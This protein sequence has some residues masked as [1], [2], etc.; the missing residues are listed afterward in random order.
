MGEASDVNAVWRWASGQGVTRVAQGVA[1]RRR[2]EQLLYVR[3]LGTGALCSRLPLLG[4]LLLVDG[5]FGVRI[6]ELPL[7]LGL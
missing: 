3:E 4:V 6:T 1:H 5:S 2:T 7:P